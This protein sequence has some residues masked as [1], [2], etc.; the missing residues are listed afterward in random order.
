[1]GRAL[2]P[3]ASART[4]EICK[5]I[6]EAEE[7][8]VIGTKKTAPSA[9]RRFDFFASVEKLFGLHFEIGDQ[10]LAVWFLGNARKGHFVSR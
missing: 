1:M 3:A 8:L 4:H 10:R 2:Q 5:A 6:R 9:G 7:L